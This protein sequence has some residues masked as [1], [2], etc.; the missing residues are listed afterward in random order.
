MLIYLNRPPQLIDTMSRTTLQPSANDSLW[1]GR[2]RKF[3][4]NYNGGR[5]NERWRHDDIA[6]KMKF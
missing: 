3:S 2:V 1:F 6:T 4:I 5:G